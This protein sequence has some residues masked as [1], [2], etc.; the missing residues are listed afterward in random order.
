M[1]SNFPQAK[2]N[3]VADLGPILTILLAGDRIAA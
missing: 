2:S 1:V 3:Q